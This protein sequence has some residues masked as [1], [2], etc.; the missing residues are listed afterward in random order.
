M[1]ETTTYSDF[2]WSRS[3]FVEACVILVGKNDVMGIYI[4]E[5]M[6]V[7]KCR[8]INSI[9]GYDTLRSLSTTGGD[10]C[11]VCVTQPGAVTYHP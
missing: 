7:G 4:R 5:Y 2:C 10:E 8:L 11:K 6:W 1:F 3:P 9:S